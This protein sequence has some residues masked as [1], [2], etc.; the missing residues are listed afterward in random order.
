[1]SI[2]CYK[3]VSRD[4]QADDDDILIFG[5][6][7]GSSSCQ[8]NYHEESHS[9]TRRCGSIP[10][11]Y[12]LNPVVQTAQ[13]P[14]IRRFVKTTQ[15]AGFPQ[16]HIA[17]DQQQQQHAFSHTS[18][19]NIAEAANISSI[20]SKFDEIFGIQRQNECY[21]THSLGLFDVP[22]TER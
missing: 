4:A 20:Q 22:K 9:Q 3:P 11:L 14:V 1:M 8:H 7:G 16:E 15:Y 13:P 18:N 5:P 10:N 6:G 21:S 12:Y 19:T 2:G 17:T